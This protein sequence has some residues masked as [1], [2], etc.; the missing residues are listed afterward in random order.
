MT[1]NFILEK[2]LLDI[3]IQKNTTEKSQRSDGVIVFLLHV[4]NT[5]SIAT[6][7]ILKPCERFKTCLDN[8]CFMRIKAS[9]I[10]KYNL[11]RKRHNMPV[12]PQVSTWWHLLPSSWMLSFLSQLRTEI[13]INHRTFPYSFNYMLIYTCKKQVFSTVDRFLCDLWG[14]HMK[15][16]RPSFLPLVAFRSKN[17][18]IFLLNSYSFCRVYNGN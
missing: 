11:K 5:H 8:C 9:L 15:L 2:R 4:F 10:V 13:R 12:S 14:L 16:R 6:A 18:I 3:I 7:Q 17:G 1:R